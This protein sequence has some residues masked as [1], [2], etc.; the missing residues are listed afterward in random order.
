MTLPEDFRGG[1]GIFRVCGL[2]TLLSQICH[3]PV[4]G[5]A[6]NISEEER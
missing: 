1:R 4:I 6:S 2:H 3:G 5:I